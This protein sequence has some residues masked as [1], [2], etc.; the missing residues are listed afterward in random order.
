MVRYLVH[1]VG[2]SAI[3]P[4]RP[5][6]RTRGGVTVRCL[7][8]HSACS[9]EAMKINVVEVEID[10]KPIRVALYNGAAY[11]LV[12]GEAVRLELPRGALLTPA[13]AGG[14]D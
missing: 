7:E 8:R 9:T 6:I 11:V 13:S 10:G 4:P 5:A 12:G 3:R 1:Y 14:E 2:L